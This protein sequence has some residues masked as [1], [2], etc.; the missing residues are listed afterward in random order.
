MKIYYSFI[1]QQGWLVGFL[2]FSSVCGFYRGKIL[3]KKT[4]CVNNSDGYYITFSLPLG[5]ILNGIKN[6]VYCDF[7]VLLNFPAEKLMYPLE[8]SFGS[9]LIWQG[10][11]PDS[12]F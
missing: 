12:L 4:S 7:D 11:A 3:K 10:T 1:S 8:N 9:S 5:R 6:T 2:V